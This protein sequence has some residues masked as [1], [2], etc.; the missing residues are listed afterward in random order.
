M[1]SSFM[2]EGWRR[3]VADFAG[4]DD[5][6]GEQ[7]SY[8]P[9]PGDRRRQITFGAGTAANDGT[10]AAL[11]AYSAGWYTVSFTPT[12]SPFYVTF[13]TA[14]AV[15]AIVGGVTG[16]YC[17]NTSARLLQPSALDGHRLRLRPW[18]ISSRS[19]S[20]DVG[21]LDPV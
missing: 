21:R 5:E 19:E 20:T 8:A 2:L 7:G 17:Y 1:R 9:F 3:H 13:N 16:A 11:T 18:A 4:R 15:A 10:Y 12:A 6:C 14:N